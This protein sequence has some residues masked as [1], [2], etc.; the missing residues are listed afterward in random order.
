MN[1]MENFFNWV[2]KPVQKEEVL[3]W[4]NINNMNYEKIE[5]YGDFFKS[6]NVTIT[7]T[8]FEEEN[9]ETKV[10]LSEQNKKEHFDWCWNKVL[11]NFQKE[12]INFNE[13]GEHKDYF[14]KFY[15]DTFYNSNQKK[16]KEAI[17]NFLDEVFDMNTPF[18]KSDLE[19]MTEIYKIME[20]NT[21]Q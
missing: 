18:S 6:L 15:F 13:D 19:I 2:S 14:R 9:Y 3:V 20:K 8:Y 1:S 21:S 7:D 17:P 12:N 4:F 5:L 11:K 10:N 16:I